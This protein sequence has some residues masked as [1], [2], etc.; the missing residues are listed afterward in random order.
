MSEQR[1]PKRTRAHVL[2]T[3]S[4]L[5]PLGPASDRARGQGGIRCSPP[6][7]LP[8]SM[9]LTNCV[10]AGM[11]NHTPPSSFGERVR[12]RPPAASVLYGPPGS[13]HPS[14]ET[15][16]PC[17]VAARRVHQTDTGR[18]IGKKPISDD[19]ERQARQ[20]FE[21]GGVVMKGAPY[22]QLLRPLRVKSED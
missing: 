18:G 3:L 5:A 21:T 12:S 11:I 19:S 22:V 1:L 20:F 10:F 13:T 17:A 6:L 15:S 8:L 2:E 4:Y 9:S 16:Q 7:P 14:T